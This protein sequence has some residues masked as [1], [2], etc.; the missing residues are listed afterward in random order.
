MLLLSISNLF[1]DKAI[2]NNLLY[3][4]LLPIVPYAEP[5]RLTLIEKLE[6][7]VTMRHARRYVNVLLHT[8]VRDACL[9]PTLTV[10]ME[11]CLIWIDY[12]M[13]L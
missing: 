12:L 9:D 5:I 11:S 2:L 4:L 6:L 8:S 7:Q 13:S 10:L 1:R 3:A